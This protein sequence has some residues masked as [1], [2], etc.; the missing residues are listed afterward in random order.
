V[1][2]RTRGTKVATQ[3]PGQRVATNRPPSARLG[4][5]DAAAPIVAASGDLI[6]EEALATDA[7]GPAGSSISSPD[8]RRSTPGRIKVKADSLLA[9][10][11]ATEYVY[12]GQDLRRIV[13]VA[14]VL[15]GVMFVLW[16]VLVLMGLAGIY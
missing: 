13:L 7:V 5:T 4:R 10:R 3:R 2:K 14:A 15:F 12:V 8:V 16:V 1:A 6:V 9:A 11:A